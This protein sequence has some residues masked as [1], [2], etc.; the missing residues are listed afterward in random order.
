MNIFIVHAILLT[1]IYEDTH[2]VPV[3][4]GNIQNTT[5]QLAWTIF[6]SKD[7]LNLEWEFVYILYLQSINQQN[8][9]CDPYM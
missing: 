6:Q 7:I 9:L 8:Y 2:F 4:L 3:V 1:H 5:C